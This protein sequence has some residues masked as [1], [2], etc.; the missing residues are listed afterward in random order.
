M[1]RRRVTTTRSPKESKKRN[2]GRNGRK[3]SHPSLK[4]KIILLGNQTMPRI[5]GSVS[6]AMA[7]IELVSAQRWRRSMP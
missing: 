2:S 5:L 1:A 4:I 6:F 3:A 7:L